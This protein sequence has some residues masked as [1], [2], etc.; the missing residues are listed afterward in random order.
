MTVTLVAGSPDNV[1]STGCT[2]ISNS[3]IGSVAIVYELG[4]TGNNPSIFVT[5]DTTNL[6]AS[7]V[8]LDPR[9]TSFTCADCPELV[10]VTSPLDNFVT[11]DTTNADSHVC[12]FFKVALEQTA[13]TTLTG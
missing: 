9:T 12:F 13:T 8:Y 1:I 3:Q 11:T 4:T 10:I 7:V 6:G 2:T 5:A